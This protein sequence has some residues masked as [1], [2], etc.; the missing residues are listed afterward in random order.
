MRAPLLIAATLLA[1]APA[2]GA[3]ASADAFLSKEIRSGAGR[4]ELGALAAKKGAAPEVRRYGQ[5]LGRDAE[6]KRGQ[7]ADLARKLGLQIPV[8][9]DEDGQR[10][11]KTLDELAGPDFDQA[12]ARY[13]LYDQRQDLERLEAEAK[14]GAP[15]VV[16]DLVRA[17]LPAA[18]RDQASARALDHA[19][20]NE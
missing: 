10:Q 6:R 18:R 3:D 1:A 7:E 19:V 17:E 14:A 9:I 11:L 4:V 8:E 2:L 16:A 13:V 15:P 5:R 20:G 12:F